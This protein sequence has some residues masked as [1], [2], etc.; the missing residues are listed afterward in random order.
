MG[1]GKGVEESLTA[2]DWECS[3]CSQEGNGVDVLWI[4]Q[5]IICFWWI[6][7]EVERLHDCWWVWKMD[8]MYEEQEFERSPLVKCA[9]SL[10]VVVSAWLIYSWEYLAF[11]RRFFLWKMCDSDYGTARIVTEFSFAYV[12]ALKFT[13]GCLGRELATMI[14][15]ARPISFSHS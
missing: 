12:N 10:G 8:K 13:L 9:L 3:F 6:C 2:H 11:K 15:L 5:A 14:Y 4:A 7:L 1:T